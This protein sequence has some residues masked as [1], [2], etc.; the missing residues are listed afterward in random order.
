MIVLSLVEENIPKKKNT[1]KKIYDFVRN[2]FMADRI[3]LKLRRSIH[4]E[5]C[6]QVLSVFTIIIM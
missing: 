6:L 3:A 2:M 4:K 1:V 5:V